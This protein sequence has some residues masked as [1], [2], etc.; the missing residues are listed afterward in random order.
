MYIALPA[1]DVMFFKIINMEYMRR[2]T[3][4]WTLTLALNHQGKY[5]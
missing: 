1:N 3:L 4:Q 5:N 2:Y